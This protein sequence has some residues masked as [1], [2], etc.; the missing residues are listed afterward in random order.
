MEEVFALRQPLVH[1]N[2]KSEQ[3]SAWDNSDEQEQG[4]F[5]YIM[6]QLRSARQKGCEVGNVKQQNRTTVE[7]TTADPA[8]DLRKWRLLDESGRQT[9]HYLATDQQVEEW[10]QTI[11]D[12]YHLG[13][14]LVRS[15]ARLF[16]YTNADI[17][18][19]RTC[20]TFR[21]RRHLAPQ[22]TMAYR[23]SHIYSSRRAI[24]PVSMEDLCFF[25]PVS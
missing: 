1:D 23:F 15:I 17:S 19:S 10:P 8:T 14:P 25:Y 20:Q 7:T 24:G 11:A 13:L 2:G 18:L 6:A 5:F 16:L 3:W 21:E 4:N 22:L 9:W 12:K